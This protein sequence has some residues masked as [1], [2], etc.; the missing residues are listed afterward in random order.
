M[1]AKLWTD[2]GARGNPGPAAFGYVLEAEKGTVLAAHGEAIGTAT[3]NVAEY[4]A[5]IAGLEKAAEVGVDDLVVVS[6]SELLVKQMRGEYKVKSETL[7]GLF[8]QASALASQ[9]GSVRYTAVRREHNELADR[10]VNEALDAG[11]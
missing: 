10:L 1:K 6:D 3:N 11:R 5:L 9:L 7:R 8:E 4:R 2:G